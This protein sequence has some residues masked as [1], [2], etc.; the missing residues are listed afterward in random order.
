MRYYLKPLNIELDKVDIKKA[1]EASN[2]AISENKYS[3]SDQD[4]KRRLEDQKTFLVNYMSML[5]LEKV[6]IIFGLD[7]RND[8]DRGESFINGFKAVINVREKSLAKEFGLKWVFDN[9]IKMQS[10]NTIVILMGHNDLDK[11]SFSKFYIYPFFKVSEL[12][13]NMEKEPNQK[14]HNVIHSE[15]LPI[16]IDE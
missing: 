11:S 3:H 7:V 13:F 12:S 5:A 9:D 6:G 10:P 8:Y 1:M 2:E 4:Q 14:A 15:N 16:L